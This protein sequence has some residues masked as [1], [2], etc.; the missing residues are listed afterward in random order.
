MPPKKAKQTASASF[1]DAIPAPRSRTDDQAR[2]PEQSPRKQAVAG[3][4][5]AQKQALADNLQLEITERARKLR[6]QYAL[7]AQALRSRLEMRVNRIPQVLRKRKMQDLLDEHA[8]RARP[9]PSAPLAV[10]EEQEAETTEPVK[11]G[12]KRS[13]DE[14]STA[15]PAENNAEDDKE[16][17]PVQPL[18][19]QAAQHDLPNPK[20]RAKTALAATANTK[21]ARTASRKVVP[22]IVLSPKSHNSQTLPRSPFKMGGS[23]EK[24][25]I[26]PISPVKPAAPTGRAGTTRTA[27]RQASKKFLTAPVGIENEARSSEASN[28]STGTTVIVTKATG[29]KG[30][31]AAGA[32]KATASTAAKS[33]AGTKKTTATAVA[34]KENVPP[35]VPTAAA[36]RSLRKRG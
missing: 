28:A 36:G 30:R 34:K 14:I 8:E 17:A 33:G 35:P 13:S 22:S 10:Q 27:S 3:I 7:Q 9:K 15:S 24:P 11:K 16:N 2:T 12:T 1:N 31:P 26:R 4:T 23:P 6:A 20:K 21:A 19:S 18:S 29:A 5:Q 25:S 32:K